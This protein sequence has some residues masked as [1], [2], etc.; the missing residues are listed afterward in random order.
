LGPGTGLGLAYVIPVARGGWHVQETFGGHMVAAS[1]NDEQAAIIATL[2]ADGHAV[3]Y[4]DLASGRGLPALYRAVCKAAKTKPIYGDTA[5]I[6]ENA[7]DK[8]VRTT[9][10]LFHEFLGLFA[11]NAAVTG[12]AFG[13]LYLDG[14]VIQKIYE[15]GL[16]DS[17][18]FVRGL[19]PECVPVVKKALQDVPVYLVNDPFIALRG[20][21]E[22]YKNA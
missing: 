15:G 14:G 10:R 17:D 5:E 3:V 21:A 12:H 20:L 8:H 22:L 13:G 1:L 16:F 6:F 11:H 2:R 9:L 18:A 19:I 4:E 7:K